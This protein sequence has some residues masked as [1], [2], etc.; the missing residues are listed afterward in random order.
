MSFFAGAL[1][2]N[3]GRV[4]GLAAGGVARWALRRGGRWREKKEP[5]LKDPK[6]TFLFGATWYL[7]KV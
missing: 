6:G 4:S 5:I 1:M 2:R 3:E 7:E